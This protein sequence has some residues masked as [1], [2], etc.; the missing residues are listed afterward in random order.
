MSTIILISPCRSK[1][2][3]DAY[4]QNLHEL[5]A[6]HV[7]VHTLAIDDEWLRLKRHP[8]SLQG[9]NESMPTFKCQAAT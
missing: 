9:M 8:L 4:L 6:G 5:C 7:S 1:T 3:L 2:D